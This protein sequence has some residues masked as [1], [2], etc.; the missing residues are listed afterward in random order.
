LLN[1]SFKIA[2]NN[3][4]LQVF[5]P[6]SS[7]LH[8]IKYISYHTKTLVISADISNL[9]FRAVIFKKMMYFTPT[10]KRQK[11]SLM[12][13]KESILSR[14]RDKWKTFLERTLTFI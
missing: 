1:D 9:S 13:K 10:L 8:L 11:S 3:R 4:L 7:S 5:T 12:Q 6:V 2:E 14:R